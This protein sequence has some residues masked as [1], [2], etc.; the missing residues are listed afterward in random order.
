MQDALKAALLALLRPLVRYLVGQGCTYGTLV[1]LLKMVYVDETIRH[2]GAL[3]GRPLT[4]SRLT[5]MTGIH[6]KEVKRLRE[7]LAEGGMDVGLRADA[8]VASKV[9]ALWGARPEFLSADRRPLRLS[10]RA[11]QGPDFE[12]LTRLAK[13]DMRPRAILDE[14][15]R[16]GVAQVDPAD[17]RIGLLRMAYISDLPEDKLAFLGQNVG[18]HLQSAVHNLE[19]RPPFIERALFFDAL[20]VGVL[21]V[22]RPQLEQLGANVLSQAHAQVSQAE[23]TIP[24]SASSEQRRMRFGVYYF[25]EPAPAPPTPNE[26]EK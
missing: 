9:V 15:V 24:E 16:A 3:G 4:D 26:E 13:A 11:E 7:M 14:L 2:Y 21:D 8:N 25:E 18:D 22:I 23:A 17:G 5:L 12:T 6:R 1:D 20:P 19:H 10:M